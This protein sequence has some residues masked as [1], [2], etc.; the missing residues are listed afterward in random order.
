MSSDFSVA[1]IQ[2]PGPHG[3]AASF[4]LRM[5]APAEV[6]AAQGYNVQVCSIEAAD[7]K[8]DVVVLNR[9]GNREHVKAIASL[10]DAGYCVVIDVDDDFSSVPRGHLIFNE[11]PQIHGYVKWAAKLSSLVTVSTPALVNVYGPA[12][13][14]PNFIPEVTLKTERKPHDG[15][16]LGWTGSLSSHP[17]DL[18]STQGGVGQALAQHEDAEL[19]FIGQ[20]N[21]LRWVAQEL[22]YYGKRRG[23][24]FLDFDIYH[25]GVAQ[26]D[27]GI[28]P[29]ESSSFSEAKSFLKG[30][31]YA[32]CGVPFVASSTQQYRE[33][34][35]LGAGRLAKTQGDWRHEVSK[36]LASAQL[37]AERA[38]AAREVA[39]RLTIERNAGAYWAAWGQALDRARGTL[40]EVGTCTVL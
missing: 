2:L 17:R 39:A 38:A 11:A 8:T 30:L 33:L 3:A 9:P 10:I 5:Q 31:E 1:V 19:V 26:F 20:R 40:R 27:V 15:T 14:V 24:G 12:V 28:V 4:R 13:V 22:K 32:A 35:R 29:L 18:K 25:E 7:S 36:L 23:C 34:A 37:R 21:H 16:W 6:L